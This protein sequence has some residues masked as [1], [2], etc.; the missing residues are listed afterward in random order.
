MK[1]VRE[2]PGYLAE[3]DK[4]EFEAAKEV[5]R[6]GKIPHTGTTGRMIVSKKMFD[7]RFDVIERGF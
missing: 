2:S 1:I 6:T 4:K 5:L 7:Y 3:Q